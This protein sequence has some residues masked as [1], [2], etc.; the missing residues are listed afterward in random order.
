[1]TDFRIYKVDENLYNHIQ[2]DFDLSCD[3][4]GDL[5][6]SLIYILEITEE[7]E[8]KCLYVGQTNVDPIIRLKMHS[9]NLIFDTVKMKQLESNNRDKVNFEEQKY[10]K[11]LNPILQHKFTTFEKQNNEGKKSYIEVLKWIESQN[12]KRRPG[13]PR[14]K[15]P[16]KLINVAV[17]IRLYD[18]V[19]EKRGEYG[20]NITQYINS[21]IEKDV[22]MIG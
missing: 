8:S 18:K 10:I 13:R 16:S 2:L 17:P 15:E 11:I 6:K 14:T 21:L 5:N 9:S 3:S 1:M 7:N 4:N 22:E 12:T 20:L 19:I